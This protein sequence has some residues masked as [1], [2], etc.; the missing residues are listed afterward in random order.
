MELVTLLAR[1]LHILAAALA[2]GVPIY[3]RF[4]LVPSLAV[5]DDTNRAK[6]QEAS[7]A[8]WRILVYASIVIFLT[9]GLYNFFGDHAHWRHL[10]VA[11]PGRYHMYFAIKFVLA[12]ALFFVQSALVGS[13]AKLAFIRDNAK[14]W[15]TASVSLGIAIMA[16]SGAMR[17]MK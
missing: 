8:R 11:T 16:I 9:T 10:E 4:V 15:L 5:L 6:L 3:I 1:W 13:S 2:V 7:A 12:L 17:F 14:T